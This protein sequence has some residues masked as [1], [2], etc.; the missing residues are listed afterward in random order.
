MLTISR[1]DIPHDVVV[2]Y[3]VTSRFIKLPIQNYL[4]LLGAWD[5]L[6]SAQLALINAVNS[7]K[8]RFV[9][10]ALARRLGKTYIANVIGQLVTLV[11]NSAVL[12]VSPN[13]SLSS[14]SFEL[15]RRFI[16]HFDLEI[17]RN[18]LKDKIIELDNGS[19]IRM[20]SISTVDSCVG[21]SYDLIIFDEAAL[22]SAGEAAFNIQLRPTLD[23]PGSKAIFISTPR[24]RNNWFSQFFQRGFSTEFPEWCSIQADY[25][26]NPRMS[27]VD[28]QEAQRSMTHQQFQQEYCASFT[29]FE[30]QVYKFDQATQVSDCPPEVL[31][32]LE[33]FAGCDPGYRDAT[34]FVVL[35]YDPQLEHYWVL[36]CYEA[37]AKT[38][39]EHCLK[40]HELIGRYAVDPV[41]IDSAAAQFAAD[42]AYVHNIATVSAKKAVLPGITFVQNI[43]EQN[44]LFVVPGAQRVLQVLD[45]YR[46]DTSTPRE[47]PV[48]DQYSHTADA[49]RYALYSYVV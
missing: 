33:C 39:A 46:W 3:P 6:N 40:F 22:T 35:G 8:Y 23:K 15:Q 49:L 28:V 20:G 42:L 17:A 21:R 16:G 12:L 11:P 13:Y 31:Q 4:K 9:C 44:R 26:E 14:I 24:G 48:H 38:T 43:V 18:N 47:R 2:E 29:E 32:R 19:T 41:F 5:E 10:A 45:Q 27:A 1:N 37:S 36:D 7:P 34:A 30:G 25:L